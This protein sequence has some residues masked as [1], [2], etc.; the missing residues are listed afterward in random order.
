MRRLPLGF[1]YGL[2]IGLPLV[3]AAAGA[4]PLSA[5]EEARELTFPRDAFSVRVPAG[6]AVEQ[7]ASPHGPLTLKRDG[8]TIEFASPRRSES[9]VPPRPGGEAWTVPGATRAV[10]EE[11]AKDDGWSAS[12]TAWRSAED[13]FLVLTA[14]GPKA[15]EKAVVEARAIFDSLDVREFDNPRVHADWNGRWTVEVPD[16]WTLAADAGGARLASP[17]KAVTLSVAAWGALPLSDEQRKTADLA[18]WIAL[19]IRGALEQKVGGEPIASHEPPEIAETGIGGGIDARL[20]GFRFQTAA[21]KESGKHGFAAVLATSV[22]RLVLLAAEEGSEEAKTGH[23]AF[24]SF[25]PDTTAAARTAK[26]T[27]AVPGA[28]AAPTDAF[29]REDAPKVVFRLPAGWKAGSPTS[30]MRLAQYAIP[31]DHPVEMVVYF[32][33]EGGGGGVEANLARWKG[34][35]EGG[36]AKTESVAVAEGIKATLLD[37]TGSYGSGMPGSGAA[38]TSIAD[39]RMLAAVI[40][41]PGGP[42][43][44]KGVGPKATMAAAAAD[45]RAWVTSFRTKK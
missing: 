16:G 35:M 40:E 28:D 9:G 42:L 21:Q 3:L 15:A 37:V 7:G 41:C 13:D 44:M 4:P 1:A 18:G 11:A 20:A 19:A 23:D 32:F 29:E 27:P 22:H 24:R 38:P 25:E 30:S 2:T 17:S 31:G 10:R 26:P 5:G 14:A 45:F 39:A 36:E 43:F 6:W 33:G 8:V 34:Q 12:A